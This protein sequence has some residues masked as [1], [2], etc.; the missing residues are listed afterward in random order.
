MPL[1]EDPF[2]RYKFQESRQKSLK[3]KKKKKQTFRCDKSTFRV[4]HAQF[5][6]NKIEFKPRKKLSSGWDCE[7][8]NEHVTENGKQ[9][10]HLHGRS[11]GRLSGIY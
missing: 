3:K 5:D 2:S 10:R 6:L 9:T 1:D 7:R 4:N 8:S 11:A